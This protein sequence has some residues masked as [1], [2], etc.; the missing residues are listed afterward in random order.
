MTKLN[1]VKEEILG[2]VDNQISAKLE[3]ME[4][5]LQQNKNEIAMLKEAKPP[6]PPQ[7]REDSL[8]RDFLKEKCF[9]RRRNL[10]L[11]GLQEPENGVE[12]K[13][14]IATL[15]QNRLSIPKPAIELA[16]RVG[17]EPGRGPRPILITFADFPQKL[18]VWYKKSVL[19]KDQS[20]K[21]WL[22]EDLPKPLWTELNA[23]LKVQK[24]AK[25]LPEKYPDVKIKDFQIR[26]QGRFYN[27][28]ELE[29]LPQDLQASTIT[30]PQSE[31]AVVFFGRASPLSNHHICSFKISGK[32]FTC[33]EHFLAWQK[34]SLSEDESLA[35]SVLHMKD[36]SEH[37]KVLNA[38]REDHPDKWAEKVENILRTALRAK[39]KQN[40]NLR[41]FLCDTHP[42][43]IGEASVN[44]KWGIGMPLTNP[45]VLN[46]NKWNAEGNLLGKTLEL[47][48]EEL[49]QQSKKN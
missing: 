31:D 28:N 12:D 19:N 29:Q 23:L 3:R 48:R 33:V 24:R 16:Y 1:N 30:T 18:T 21:L 34:A 5:E 38:L 41:E 39:F 37:K 6:P 26:I 13:D 47:I 2:E 27:A 43:R 46:I 44:Q 9:T 35:P 40:Q 11:M 45:D 25:A 20:Q 8:R 42:K 22:Q 36:P 17:T 15:L 32:T 10:M 4:R 14:T 7:Q 49:I